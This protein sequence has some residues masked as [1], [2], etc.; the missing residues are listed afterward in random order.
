MR[1]RS[2]GRR[3]V[4]AAV[5][6][7]RDRA[8]PDP[9]WVR[10]K[11]ASLGRRIAAAVLG[12]P[13]RRPGPQSAA[14][15]ESAQ[16][17]DRA[18]VQAQIQTQKQPQAQ[19]QDPAASPAGRREPGPRSASVHLSHATGAILTPG[20][21]AKRTRRK[22]D[23][24]A[25]AP[26]TPPPAPQIQAAPRRAPHLLTEDRAD[27][28]RLL[29][30][31]LRTAELPSRRAAVPGRRL[32]VEQ[33]RTM[34]LGA[35]SAIAACAASEYQHYVRLREELRAPEPAVAQVSGDTLSQAES[36]ATEPAGAG[37]VQVAA[38]LAPV[39]AGIAAVLFLILGYALRA[40]GVAPSTAQPVIS[41]GFICA[42]ITAAGAVIAMA[43]LI[44]AAWRNGSTSLRAPRSGDGRDDRVREVDLAR[45]A[46]REA[47][48]ERGI[49]PFL[50]EV[51]ETMTGPAD[52]DRSGT[53]PHVPRHGEGGSRTP[54]LGYSRPDF[55]SPDFSSPDLTSPDYGG[56]EE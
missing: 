42:A 24:S 21:G 38:V 35:S 9:H 51:R 15:T 55:T 49:R 50:R 4:A 31:A 12:V 54:F 45:D 53:A 39:L 10:P 44:Y 43:S 6:G 18:Q 40:L 13:L 2:D 14:L 5:L 19:A 27:F 37:S 47:L 23:R 30:E 46:W 25:D 56:T 36:E 7:L 33:V 17:Q 16:D 1:A 41:A 11:D 32:G 3:R 28:E 22:P 8:V 48:L 52:T 20:E 29:D 34:A 26:P